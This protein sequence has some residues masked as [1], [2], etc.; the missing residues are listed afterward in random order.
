VT[1]RARSRSRR[2]ACAAVLV[3][4][5]LAAGCF[6]ERGVTGPARDCTLATDSPV[7]GTAGVVV[8][9]RD[10]DFAQPEL[11]IAAGTRVTWVNCGPREGH[12]STADFGRWA[13]PML[14]PG[15][16]YSHVFDVP[17]TFDYHCA[18]HPFMRG[19]V[20]VQ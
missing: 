11:R 1:G 16:T 18:P 9:I 13:S 5:V 17:G 8:A 4:A 3:P 10:F 15:A 14:V 12:T 20:I 2:G 6:S 7:F 19:R